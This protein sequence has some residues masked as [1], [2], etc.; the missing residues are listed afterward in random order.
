MAKL[1][2]GSIRLE[3]LVERLKEDKA[4]AAAAGAAVVLG[5]ALVWRACSGSATYKKKPSVFDLSGGSIDAQ[6]V[7]NEWDNYEASYGKEAGVGIKDRSKVTQLVDV[8][9]S[10]VTDIY[11]W[12]WGQSFHF[13]PKLPGKTWASS[14]AAHETRVAAT[15]GL[16]PGMRCLDVG[17]GVGGPMR[18]IAAVS[19]AHV[20]GI[21]INQYQVGVGAG[22]AAAAGRW[23][24]CGTAARRPGRSG[25]CGAAPRRA[26]APAAG[27]AAAPTPAAA[28]PAL[29]AAAPGAAR[30]QRRW[31]G[32]QRRRAPPRRAARR[33]PGQSGAR[34]ASRRPQPLTPAPP[35]APRAPAPAPQVDRA[36][37]HNAR[38][39]LA[40]LTDVVRGNFLDM[41]FEAGTFDAA[42]AIEATCHA[43]K[44]EEVFGEV[45]R[46]LKPGGLFLSYEWVSTKDYD[47]SN[48]E[49]VKIIDEIN[50]GNG[51]P[52][53]RTW[54]QA[55]DA[56]KAVGL[57]LVASIDLAVASKGAG[58]WYG[59]L[60]ELEWQNR[61][62]HAIVS[63]VDALY[64]APK[65]LKQVHN[66][67]VEVAR[68]LVAGGRTGVFTPMHM[69]VFRKK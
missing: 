22:G 21:T 20:T 52:E 58:P 56:G 47:A 13:S 34:R 9:Y 19:G 11:E 46:V 51:L 14:E 66:M 57:E 63:T 43:D 41:P 5:G 8:F 69:L 24:G 61:V 68:S 40:E 1:D 23:P 55:E 39:G 30:A 33:R 38:N 15:L 25:G 4:A 3:G 65:G 2:L 6:H 44:L 17:C 59:R 26:A 32:L 31:R 45:A 60:E 12:G 53:M 28:A 27:P 50:F 35:R 16:K 54:K 67:L 29:V 49:H 62:S 37:A 7:K 42:Y 36:T 64:L 18:T 10:L 48:P